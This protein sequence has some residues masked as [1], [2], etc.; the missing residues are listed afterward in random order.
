MRISDVEN[1][2]LSA[3]GAD[4]ALKEFFGPRADAEDAKMEMYKN[5]SKQGYT[6]LNDLPNDLSK[7][8]TLNTVNSYLIGAGITSDLIPNDYTAIDNKKKIDNML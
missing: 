5:I 1:Y 4:E 8:Q 6:Y 7:K 3:I 2:A